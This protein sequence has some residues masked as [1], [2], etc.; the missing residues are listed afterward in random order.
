MAI[1]F[2]NRRGTVSENN[3][4]TG[5]A[6]ELSVDTT[7]NELRLHDGAT[8]GGTLVSGIRT[9]S[10]I[11]SFRAM[12]DTPDKVYTTGYH[13]EDDGAFGSHFFEWDIT[14]T[15]ADNG[16]TTIQV[17]G[18]V[19]GRYKLR[20]S[21]A[22][23]V[24]WFGAVGDGTTDDTAS[25]QSAIDNHNDL[26]VPDDNVFL[27]GVTSAY[28]LIDSKTDFKISGNGTIKLA[29]N[30]P[31]LSSKGVVFVSNSTNV[32][33]SGIKI[34]GNNVNNT[35][36]TLSTTGLV[37]GIF[38]S[39]SKDVLIYDTKIV[40]C[41]NVGIYFTSN[42]V[43]CVATD[44]FILDSFGTELK[45]GLNSH[46]TFIGN[47][48]EYNR[49]VHAGVNKQ[50]GIAMVRDS[51]TM[52]LTGNK[53]SIGASVTLLPSMLIWI[54]SFTDIIISDNIVKSASPLSYSIEAAGLQSSGNNV[55]IDNNILDGSIAFI[56]STAYTIN[57]IKITNNSIVGSSSISIPASSLTTNKIS[58]IGNNIENTSANG[59]EINATRG[60]ISN[61][62]INQN[63]NHAIF[64][65]GTLNSVNGNILNGN[66]VVARGIECYAT[67]TNINGNIIND[68]G[69]QGIKE[70]GSADF[71]IIT[72]NNTLNT[73]GVTIIGASTISAN[74]R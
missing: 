42:S 37:S 22:V 58:V 64:L 46:G 3:S 53:L 55:L 61:N 13:T 43:R 44:N 34:D 2:Q 60:V 65:E 59:I 19:T 9:V 62:I 31:V 20:Y 29:D 48:C 36:N 16:G 35:G 24:K 1:Q 70:T 40:D 8:Q 63:G 71:N 45:V 6:G 49:D 23:N 72:S 18:I 5:A 10:T 25:I 4:F 21:G 38:I 14:C 41:N 26:L 17:T 33:I 47:V 52:I 30:S 73:G 74:N 39:E 50:D 69:S 28:L 12:T 54:R 32:S 51:G 68:F 11:D 57:N 15:D 67:Y 66:A 56:S 27:V 7:N